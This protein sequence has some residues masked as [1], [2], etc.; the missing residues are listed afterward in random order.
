MHFFSTKM[1]QN[2][3]TLGFLKTSEITKKIQEI[4]KVES[5]AEGKNHFKFLY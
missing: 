2:V 1:F 4:F 5:S 3:I